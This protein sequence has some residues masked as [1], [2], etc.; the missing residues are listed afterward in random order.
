[1]FLRKDIIHELFFDRSTIMKFF[2]ILSLLLITL[3]CSS[4]N[5]KNE[6]LKTGYFS[7]MADAALFIDC[8]TGKKYP[9]AMEGEYLKLEVA[10]LEADITS[11]EKVLVEII[12]EYEK[13]LSIEGEG[14]TN[15]LIVKKFLDL[16]TKKQCE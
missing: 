1:M 7:Y 6:Q 5:Y 13:R 3:S 9:V 2:I 10:Y 14:E 15:F 12:G 16:S 8:V 4:V 11:G